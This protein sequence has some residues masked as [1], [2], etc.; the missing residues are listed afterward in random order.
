M[1]NSI[2][3]FAAA[4]TSALVR[5]AFAAGCNLVFLTAGDDAA[6]QL[7]RKVGFEVAAR[8]MAAAG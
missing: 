8:G 7:Y 3:F 5:D 1:S 2:D 4:V 6:V